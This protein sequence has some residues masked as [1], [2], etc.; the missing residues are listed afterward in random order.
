[1]GYSPNM[2]DHLILHHHGN[3]NII[4]DCAHQVLLQISLSSRDTNPLRHHNL[5]IIL[6][7]FRVEGILYG[8]YHLTFFN[9]ELGYG[10]A[11]KSS[12]ASVFEIDRW[13]E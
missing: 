3:L 4:K 11:I 9:F 13:I 12:S 10:G 7:I 5:Y 6:L 1:M 8:K 2:N